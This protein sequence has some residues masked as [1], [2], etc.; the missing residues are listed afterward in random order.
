MTETWDRIFHRFN[1]MV[2]MEIRPYPMVFDNKRKD[3]K[4]FQRWVVTGLYRAVKWEDYWVSAK[5]E[6]I[7]QGVQ[8][9]MSGMRFLR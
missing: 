7:Q 5:V 8:G 1:R 3:L 4:A 9:M 2:E 6:C